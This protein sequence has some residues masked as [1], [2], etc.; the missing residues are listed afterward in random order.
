MAEFLNDDFQEAEDEED[1]NLVPVEDISCTSTSH[2]NEQ[3]VIGG[4]SI[5]RINKKSNKRNSEGLI[6][7]SWQCKDGSC[8]GRISSQRV[9]VNC[10]QPEDFN[11]SLTAGDN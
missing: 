1:Q 5:S 9:W 11:V 10:D 3:L 7:V 4:I 6:N 2:G 8:P